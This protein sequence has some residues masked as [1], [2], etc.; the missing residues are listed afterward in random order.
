MPD[1]PARRPGGLR[2]DA[3]DRERLN[4]G[5]NPFGQGMFRPG[6]L[7]ERVRRLVHGRPAGHQRDGGRLMIKVLCIESNDDNGYMLKM[8][9]EL[10]DEFRGA[11]GG[12]RWEGMQ[13]G[14]RRTKP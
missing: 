11:D 12:G 7:V 13:N 10:L 9:L 8:W 1:I 4:S 5:G 6:E 2:L 14:R 3:K